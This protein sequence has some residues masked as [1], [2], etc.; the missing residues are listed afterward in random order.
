MIHAPTV[1]ERVKP[2]S[3][4]DIPWQGRF[5]IIATGPFNKQPGTIEHMVCVLRG[6]DNMY[7]TMSIGWQKDEWRIL[8]QFSIRTDSL[9]DAVKVFTNRLSNDNLQFYESLSRKID[10]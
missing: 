3:W 1:H 2:H 10:E 6:D 7:Q 8:E 5:Q 4:V 9:V